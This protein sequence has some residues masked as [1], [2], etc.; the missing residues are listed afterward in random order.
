MT[1]SKCGALSGGTH[2]MWTDLV[3]FAGKRKEEMG[4]DKIKHTVNL[5][6]VGTMDPK[7]HLIVVG[8]FDDD[9][10]ED[11]ERGIVGDF[12][13]GD[14]PV[15]IANDTRWVGRCIVEN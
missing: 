3:A 8:P 10:D 9:D 7:L 12:M 13:L 11:D 2:K 5:L 4:A 6:H 1:R 15:D 14:N